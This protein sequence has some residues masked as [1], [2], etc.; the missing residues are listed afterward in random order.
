MLIMPESDFLKLTPRTSARDK[1]LKQYEV[2]VMQVFEKCK[3]KQVKDPFIVETEL[4]EAVKK[5]NETH[6]RFIFAYLKLQKIE[7]KGNIATVF[8]PDEIYVSSFQTLD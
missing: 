7:Y 1:M 3:E 4:F 8:I 2:T 5:L 6:T